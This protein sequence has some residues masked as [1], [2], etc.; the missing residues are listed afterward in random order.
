[1]IGLLIT[2]IIMQTITL[3]FIAAFVAYQW[4]YRFDVNRVADTMAAN[5]IG[6]YGDDIYQLNGQGVQKYAREKYL[7]LAF[8]V[9]L[10]SGL[11]DHV[12]DR[13]MAHVKDVQGEPVTHMGEVA[14]YE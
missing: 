13:V 12:A 7:E 2:L 14:I 8:S 11:S 9:G 5:L 10:P 6:E 3:V 1:M 4:R